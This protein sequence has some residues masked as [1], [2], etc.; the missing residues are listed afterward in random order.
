M[1]IV[2]INKFCE[3]CAGSFQTSINVILWAINNNLKYAN[4]LQADFTGRN[5]YK[6][7]KQTPTQDILNQMAM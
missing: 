4:N 1:Q 5:P 6:F 3:I 7:Y 2:S